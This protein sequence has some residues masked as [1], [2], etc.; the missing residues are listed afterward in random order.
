[1]RG[2]GS[3]GMAVETGVNWPST[4][5]ANAGKLATESRK[6]LE[7]QKLP[8]AT[9]SAMK[10]GCDDFRSLTKRSRKYGRRRDGVIWLYVWVSRVAGVMPDSRYQSGIQPQTNK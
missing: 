1:M 9:A 3:A 5:S 7:N 2:H 4:I 8:G 6:G 10:S